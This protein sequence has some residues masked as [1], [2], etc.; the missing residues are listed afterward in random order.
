MKA[1][2][3]R[4]GN[5]IMELTSDDIFTVKPSYYLALE[6]NLECSRPIPLTDEWFIKCQSNS[7]FNNGFTYRKT[8]TGRYDIFCGSVFITVI[9]FVHELQ[10]LNFALLGEELIFNKEYL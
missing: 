8:N 9:E 10:N 3:L 4:I 7:I 6:V 2:E 5:Y 1:N